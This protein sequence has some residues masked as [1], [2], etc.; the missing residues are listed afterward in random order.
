MS[1]PDSVKGFPNNF[2]NRN[3]TI[4]GNHID[5]S[6]IYAIFVG[7][8]DGIRIINN[9]IGQTFIR[10]SAFDAGKLYGIKPDSAI[11]VGRARNVTIDNNRVARSRI[12]K[13]AVAVDG[14]CEKPSVHVGNNSL[15]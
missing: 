12:A 13:T 3:I 1:A 6:H 11:F 4:E 15:T 8:A 5:D 7:N 2:Q 14:T 9:T 10:G